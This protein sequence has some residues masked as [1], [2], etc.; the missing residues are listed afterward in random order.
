M[1]G[2]F[3]AH[4]ITIRHWHLATAVLFF[5]Y[6]ESCNAQSSSRCSE[7]WSAFRSFCSGGDDGNADFSSWCRGEC[8]TYIDTGVDSC[9]AAATF[10]DKAFKTTL[11]YLDDVYCTPCFL[12]YERAVTE[13][14]LRQ[15]CSQEPDAC[16]GP[17]NLALRD[18][19]STCALRGSHFMHAVLKQQVDD[20]IRD[21]CTLADSAPAP[22]RLS[23]PSPPS[24]SVA[25]ELV[26]LPEAI[27]SPAPLQD[28]VASCAEASAIRRTEDQ[29]VIESVNHVLIW[30]A[31][32]ALLVCMG[33]G[34]EFARMKLRERWPRTSRGRR[35]RLRAV[36]PNVGG[37]TAQRVELEIAAAGV[38]VTSTQ[39]REA[40][41]QILMPSH[42]PSPL[43]RSA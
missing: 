20:F 40:S 33:S 9:F 18:A 3:R 16:A 14:R 2:H 1:K 28:R 10:A 7:A 17:C 13:C 26:L 4:C 12:L 35:V 22:P 5:F 36:R 8:K 24:S 15:G 31:A 37:G 27:V 29:V 32:F 19:S 34:L 38:N 21:Q 6:L 11:E 42:Q 30:L 41:R 43:P 25:G 23:F 39:G